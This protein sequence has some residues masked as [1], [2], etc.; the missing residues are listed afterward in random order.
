[1]TAPRLCCEQHRELDEGH[2]REFLDRTHV[3]LETF[4]KFLAQHHVCC[5]DENCRKL[6][7][8]IADKLGDLYQLAGRKESEFHRKK[9]VIEDDFAEKERR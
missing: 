9:K 3:Q 8:E 6:A 7:D 4:D 5:K 2:W 1:M